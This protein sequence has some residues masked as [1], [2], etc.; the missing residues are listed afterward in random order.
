MKKEED[1]VS[2]IVPKMGTKCL[3]AKILDVILKIVS[4]TN[5]YKVNSNP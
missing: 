5:V 4:K 2:I 1:K 3:F